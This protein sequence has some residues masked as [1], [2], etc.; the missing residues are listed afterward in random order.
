MA[1][2]VDINDILEDENSIEI[3]TP[4]YH[5]FKNSEK[6]Y[7]Q[8]ICSSFA[9]IVHNPEKTRVVAGHFL[10]M[11]A[12]RDFQGFM[13]ILRALLVRENDLKVMLI[14]ICPLG[15]SIREKNNA[16]QSRGELLNFLVREGF[17]PKQIQARWIDNDDEYYNVFIDMR[18]GI[19]HISKEDTPCFSDV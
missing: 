13:K 16:K 5:L 9:I 15:S 14:G 1:N 11:H 3:D 10:D 2:L 7:L 8:A 4:D 18:K 17:D 19:V 12:D 6:G